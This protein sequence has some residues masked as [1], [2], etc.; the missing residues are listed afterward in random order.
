MGRNP[1]FFAQSVQ[2]WS[3]AIG[4]IRY[5]AFWFEAACVTDT[6]AHDTH[7]P[8]F[9]LTGGACGLSI[10]DDTIVGVDQIIG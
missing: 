4:R 1:A 9:S 2:H 8:H 5:Q 7:G 6:V 10:E 3:R